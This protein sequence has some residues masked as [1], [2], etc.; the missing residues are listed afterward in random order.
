MSTRPTTRTLLVLM[1]M[2][3]VLAVGAPTA[4]AQVRRGPPQGRQ[5]MERQIMARFQQRVLA[6]LGLDPAQGRELAAA[7]R[8]FQDERRALNQRDM[9]LRQRLRGTS[10]LLSDEAAREALA[11]MVAIQNDEADL[12]QREQARLLEIMSPPQVVRFYTLRD[13][14]SQRIRR[15]QGGGPPGGPGGAAGLGGGLPF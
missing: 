14:F 10:T 8:G 12:L 5:E 3:V 15:L 11:E 1:T 13:E 7:V 9:Q 4:G 6:E 2:A